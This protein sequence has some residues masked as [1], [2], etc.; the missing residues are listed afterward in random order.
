MILTIVG[1]TGNLGK[2]LVSEGLKRGHTLGGVAPD[3]DKVKLDARIALYK[4][5]SDD[6]Q[7][8]VSAF[9][10]S[11]VVISIFPPRLNEPDQYTGQLENMIR[12]VKESGVKRLIGLVG[13]SGAMVNTGELLVNTDYFQETTRHYYMNVLKSWELYR[14]EKDLDWA[15]V[16]PAARM[17]THMKSQGG[18]YRVRTDGYLV[19]TDPN[20]R[21][22]FD[23]SQISYADCAC[24]I[25]DEAEQHKYTHKFFSVGY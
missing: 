25:L 14:N 2:E 13:S 19:V 23:V 7:I 1:I 17:Q 9:R 5:T 22:Y 18:V 6:I 4:G 24:A 8:M 16:V 3:V 15:A 10:G 20:S 12:A 21:R 11:D